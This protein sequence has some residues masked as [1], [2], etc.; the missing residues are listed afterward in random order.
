M[1]DRAA[2][3]GPVVGH[4]PRRALAVRRG[5]G[6]RNGLC[7]V[8]L[9]HGEPVRRPT[10]R[11]PCGRTVDSTV[12]RDGNTD[13]LVAPR[14]DD[15][16]RSAEPFGPSRFNGRRNRMAFQFKL[17]R[18]DGTP[19]DPPTLKA[20]VPNWRDGDTIGAGAGP[21]APRGRDTG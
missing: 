3:P 7:R 8:R 10:A 18:E 16:V 17:E 6:G 5:R 19:A 4:T 21:H 1:F 15:Q 13:F 12:A 14:A 9:V 2:G 20:A 11:G